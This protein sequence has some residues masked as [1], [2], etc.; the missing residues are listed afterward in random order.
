[1]TQPGGTEQPY[2]DMPLRQ[3]LGT[4]ASGAPA[5]GGGTAAALAVTLGAGLC[6]MAARLSA[7]QL[8]E[9]TAGQLTSEADRIRL[10]SASLMQADAE[11]YGRVISAMRSRAGDDPARD[12]PAGRERAVAAALSAAAD[13]PMEIIALGAEVARL[14]AR[15]AA[16]GNAVLRGD[17][18]AAAVLA[19]AGTRAA[20]VLVGINLARVPDDERHARAESLLADAE[21]RARAAVRGV[22]RGGA[23]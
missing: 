4:L 22:A 18:A 11:A 19:A 3:F 21:R 16:D 9:E 14:A 17:A 15:L 20:A 2:L 8:D 5:P 13:V 23:A 12:D 7:R 1:M 10:A 6:A